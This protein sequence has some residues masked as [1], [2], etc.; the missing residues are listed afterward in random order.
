MMMMLS[1]RKIAYISV[2][3]GVE[4]DAKSEEKKKA[5]FDD[6]VKELWSLCK[7]KRK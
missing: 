5:E 1:W 3:K 2:E 4:E 7:K 6:N